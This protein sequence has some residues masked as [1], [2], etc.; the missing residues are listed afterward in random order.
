MKNLDKIE[1]AL[2]NI[3]W[4]YKIIGLT[5]LFLSLSIVIGL[6]SGY[7]VKHQEQELRLLLESSQL[8]VKAAISAG[9]AISDLDVALQSL[10]T[11]QEKN[12]IRQSAIKTIRA[13]SILDESLQRLSNVD[14]DNKRVVT[15]T[16]LLREMRPNQLE[17][18]KAAKKND[19]SKALSLFKD[20]NN[21]NLKARSIANELVET[22]QLLLDSSLQ[23][24]SESSGTIFNLILITVLIGVIFGMALSYVAIRMLLNPLTETVDLAN[25]MGDGDLSSSIIYKGSDETSQLLK[26]LEIMQ[27]KLKIAHD[28][29]EFN[30][31]IRQ[32]LDNVAT[33]VMVVNP[34][35]EI[36]YINNLMQETLN[37]QQHLI[38][39]NI[40]TFKADNVIGLSIQDLC[41]EATDDI[42]SS[43][44]MNRVN[45]GDLR[46]NTKASKVISKSDEFLGVVVEWID[47][48]LD[49][50]I[51][52]EV[53]SLVDCALE[54]DL[55]NRISLDNKQGYYERLSES[56]NHLVEVS[57]QI[58]N[59]TV[60]VLGA[61]SEGDLTARI[62][63]KY[64]GAFD[65]L[66]NDA[67][68]TNVRLSEMIA[69]IKVN[70]CKVDLAASE[71]FTGNLDLS[72]RTENQAANL[73]DTSASME[74]MTSTVRQ[75]AHNAQLAD[76]M[77]VTARDHAQHGTVTVESAIEAMHEINTSSAQISNIITVI[78]EIAFQTN[79][80]AL[81]AAVEAA[82]A[83]EQGRGFAVVASEV[84]NLA[85][86][87][88][89]A[90][91]EIKDLIE[92]SVVK[93]KEGAKLVNQSGDT[94]NEITKSI[95]EVDDI[96]GDITIASQEQSL[97]IEQANIAILKMDETTQ[98]NAALVEQISASAKSMYEQSNEL[99]DL[100]EFFV[101]SN[102]SCSIESVN[103]TDRRSSDRPWSKSTDDIDIAKNFEQYNAVG[104]RLDDGNWEEF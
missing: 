93:V 70:A 1:T 5:T 76:E 86:R 78:D 47:R 82:R 90:A 33:N 44:S 79:L 69:K 88:A 62:E 32:A 30:T 13:T 56:I 4:R 100:V 36:I 59:D 74:E 28:R 73:E 92:D 7:F 24:L 37:S 54:G 58:I 43:K 25:K 20:V 18:I 39:K 55:S 40:S 10:I 14:G 49:L 98:Q 50:E 77:A 104:D 51:E 11:S 99:N 89:T 34:E 103:S 63:N 87:S 2:S 60:N 26:S 91:K 23:K 38:E 96:I 71:I 68:K 84:R 31:R 85:G 19:D 75:T 66:K 46:F 101:V 12:Q 53:Q 97:G 81:N 83:G 17:L 72:K 95:K 16:K 65:K 27:D 9:I 64:H 6:G 102:N 35:K 61:M 94:L 45:I 80:L 22:E 57:E 15:L 3:S 41:A 21:V 42:L 67:N 29:A 48:T 52:D 8:R